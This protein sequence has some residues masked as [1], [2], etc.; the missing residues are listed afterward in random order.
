M[1]Y[2]NRRSLQVT[3]MGAILALAATF[4]GAA[5][6]NSGSTGADGPFNPTANTTLTMPANGVFNFT[7]VN[8]PA[9]VTVTFT[10][11]AAN[12]PVI[13]LAT[14]NVT[15]AGTVDVRGKN[16]ATADTTEVGSLGGI[17]GPGGY[18]GGRGGARDVNRR[19][20]NGLGPGAGSGGDFLPGV[21]CSA[22]AGPQGGG[23][24]GHAT[25][26]ANNASA[27]GAVNTGFGGAAYGNSLLTPLVGGSGGGGGAGSSV[28]DGFY[29]TGGGGGGG[30]ILIASS[31]TV[32]VSGSA[33]TAAGGGAGANNSSDGNRVAGTGGGGSGGAIRIVAANFVGS[34]A[35][36]IVTGGSRGS[37]PF[38]SFGGALGGNGGVGRVSVQIAT[39]GTLNLGGMP[40]LLITSVAGI[41]APA[42]PT[43]T[44]DVVIPAATPNPVTVAFT[45][46]GIPVTGTSTVRVTVTPQRGAASSA[47]G[48][49]SGNSTSASGTVDVSIPQGVSTLSAQ[50]A[51]TVTVAMG[52]ALSRFANNERVEK[53]TLSATVGGQS[54]VKLVTVSGREYDAPAVALQMI[55]MGG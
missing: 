54:T 20:G 5:G 2:I 12:T 41:A 22:T 47:T 43:G 52:E 26:G 6:F 1:K 11:N 55:A 3:I 44:G 53:I 36:L 35:S 51:Y 18:D 50:T 34:E 33:V 7:T 37:N 40:A 45:T 4:A 24:A 42:T 16:S 32:T 31:G 48:A 27:Q 29:G 46:T 39:T 8:I 17:G 9:G 38:V 30:A 14:G 21:C 10:K 15:I 49:L 13:W 25:A 28:F 23:G 19:A